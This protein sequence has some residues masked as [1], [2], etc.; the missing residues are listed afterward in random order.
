MAEYASRG[1]EKLAAALH[2]FQLDPTGWVCC[3]LGSHAGGFVDCLLQHGARRVHAVDPGYG[4]L[5]Y[6]LRQD[7]RVV[8]H[9]RT[10]ALRFVCPEPCQLITI[11]VGWTPQRLILPMARRGL[12]PSGVIISLIKPQYE[13]ES[14]QL[15]EGVVPAEELEAVLAICRQDVTDEG[16]VI[17]GE[18]ESPIR[19]H[20]G[21]REFLWL[22][23]N[24]SGTAN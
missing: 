10:N 20:G 5:A 14:S 1:G 15:R 12:A 24:P 13:A 7:E 19:G 11:D 4:I 21:N 17:Q 16:L 3:D 18:L 9:E 2:A 6:H 23:E 22:L 8:I